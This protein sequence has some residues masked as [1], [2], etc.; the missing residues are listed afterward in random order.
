[1]T[2]AERRR[3]VKEDR[4]ERSPMRGYMDAPDRTFKGKPHSRP[5]TDRVKRG[6]AA[7]WTL[8]PF[9]VAASSG[10]DEEALSGE[11]SEA[12]AGDV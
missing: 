11:A 4:H 1:M 12:A 5:D 9:L 8:S 10:L 2:L 3:Q 7:E 6:P